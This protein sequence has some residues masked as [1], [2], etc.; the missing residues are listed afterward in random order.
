MPLPESCKGKPSVTQVISQIWPFEPF[1]FDRALTSSAL[2]KKGVRQG[3][4]AERCL[5][6]GLSREGV[7]RSLSDFGKVVHAAAHDLGSCGFTA[8]WAGTPYE[9]HVASVVRFFKEAGLTAVAQELFVECEDYC[10]ISD[11]LYRNSRNELVLL[12]WKTWGA[13]KYLYGINDFGAKASKES[14][15]KARL[16]LSMYRR[17]IGDRFGPIRRQM[18]VWVNEFGCVPI[19]TEYDVTEFEN[20]KRGK[21]KAHGLSLPGQ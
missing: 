15:K 17:A 10:G 21:E 3:G 12:D 11:G 9:G 8:D 6:I 2:R 5:D 13:Y 14:V 20:W 19:E 4:V 1:M 18:V 7:S 16:Q